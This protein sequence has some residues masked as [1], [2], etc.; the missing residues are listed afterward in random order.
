MIAPS[1]TKALIHVVIKVTMLISSIPLLL[2]SAFSL[3]IILT[4]TPL[5][6]TL[7]QLLYP[8]PQLSIITGP[9]ILYY[10]YS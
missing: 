6:L 2:L 10:S 1:I 8:D 3:V 5:V 9:G 7:V 4:S